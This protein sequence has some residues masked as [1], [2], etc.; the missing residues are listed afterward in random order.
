MSLTLIL[1]ITN[2]FANKESESIKVKYI[3]KNQDILKGIG[4]SNIDKSIGNRLIIANLTKFQ[5]LVLTKSIK[6]DFTKSKKLDLLKA[7]I[8]K[9]NFFIIDFFTHKAK[10]AFIYL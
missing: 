5:K 7:N 10:I 3:E 8:I 1:W 9:V 6:S 4:S 2:K